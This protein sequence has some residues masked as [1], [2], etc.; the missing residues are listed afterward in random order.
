LDI[1]FN[2]AAVFAA[3]LLGL[4]REVCLVL[5][6]QLSRIRRIV[7]ATFLQIAGRFPR[8]YCNFAACLLGLC[9]LFAT[10]LL[11]VCWIITVHIAEDL[12]H[13]CWIITVHIAEDL[14]RVCCLFIASL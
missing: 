8:I 13:V 7:A 12:P 6:T 1:C 3:Y 5:P 14:Q 4:Y 11:H 9:R 10:N 2:I